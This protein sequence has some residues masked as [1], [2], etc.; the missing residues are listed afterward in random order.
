ML[1]TKGKPGW[2]PGMDR[3]AVGLQATQGGDDVFCYSCGWWSGCCLLGLARRSCLDG[4]AGCAWDHRC[5]ADGDSAGPLG[6]GL[7]ASNGGSE[8]PLTNIAA[9][10]A[11]ALSGPGAYSLD[12]VFGIALPKP[13]LLLSGLVLVVVGIAAGLLGQERK[14]T[15]VQWSRK[16]NPMNALRDDDPAI[17]T[18]LVPTLQRQPPKVAC[19]PIRRRRR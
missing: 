10:L 4:S 8:V 17:L 2:R 12:A 11:L 3:N 15:A 5:D 7:W 1:F 14:P 9:V 18:R 19:R 6:Q 16:E 13:V